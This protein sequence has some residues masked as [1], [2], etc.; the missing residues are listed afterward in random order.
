MSVGKEIGKK[1][2][3]IVGARETDKN[4]RD[5]EHGRSVCRKSCMLSVI[6]VS[7]YSSKESK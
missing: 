4:Q 5:K 3:V 6:S 1:R 2:D 7:Y